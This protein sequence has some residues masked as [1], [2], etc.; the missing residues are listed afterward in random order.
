MRRVY[1]LTTNSTKFKV[2]RKVLGEQGIKVS[3]VNCRYREIQANTLEE[4]VTAALKG[5]E[6]SPAIVEDSGLFISALRGFP[7]V[8]SS[9]AQKTLGAEYIL[10]L[11][12]SEKNRRARFESVVGFKS[13]SETK[14]FKGEVRGTI[15]KEKRG[16]RGSGFDFIF[17]PLRSEKSF[18]EMSFE[19]MV[20]NSDW[21]KSFQS[22][23][24]WFAA[25]F[26]KRRR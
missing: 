2:A 25:S 1:F 21:K 26:M 9:Y 17:R 6:I 3:R 4:V 5:I 8:Y 18:A 13:E 19:E 14:L 12:R 10:K 11:M 15:L 7:G 16:A 23:A 22:F 24:N 20:H